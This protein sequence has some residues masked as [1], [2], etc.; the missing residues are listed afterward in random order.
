MITII[1]TSTVHV[2][3]K[4][5]CLY[6]THPEVRIQTYLKSVRQWLTTQF[7]II[8]VE[9]SGYTFPELDEEKKK[10]KD[11]FQIVTLDETIEPVHLRNDASKGASEMFSIHYAFTKTLIRS[12]FII[13]V[14]ARFFI[15]ELEDYLSQH[16]L[17]RYESL[18]QH[19]R[20]RC[21]MVGCRPDHFHRIFN[22]VLDDI[23]YDGHIEDIWKARTSKGN[24]VCQPFQI[25][26]TLR[27]G[28]NE[29]Y[30][31]I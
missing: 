22:I 5:W 9:N 27:G 7:H 31:T 3:Y 6:Q 25:E 13:K 30:T 16:D 4:K 14:T 19:D 17:S 1:L 20:D 15:P 29:V 10:Y 21:E 24:L 8:L 18:T 26:P 28:Y 23:D 11:R 2:N 12:S